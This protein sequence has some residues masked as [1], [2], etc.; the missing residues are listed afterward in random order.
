M[1]SAESQERD[2]THAVD[3]VQQSAWSTSCPS[4]LRFLSSTGPFYCPAR[5]RRST[6]QLPLFVLDVPLWIEMAHQWL[7][8]NRDNPE[9]SCGKGKS[10]DERVLESHSSICH[11]D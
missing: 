4:S 8:G 10:H 9:A 5:V 7:L 1:R 6:G 11:R 3:L 2:V